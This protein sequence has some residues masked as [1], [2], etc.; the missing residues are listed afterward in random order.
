MRLCRAVRGGTGVLAR[1][2]RGSGTR[3][4][5]ALGRLGYEIKMGR[6]FV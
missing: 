1:V 4:E 2:V 3:V 5:P 6:G